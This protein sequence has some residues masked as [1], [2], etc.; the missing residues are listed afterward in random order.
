[1]GNSLS[2]INSNY[3][4]QREREREREREK[5]RYIPC[6]PTISWTSH[7]FYSHYY[8]HCLPLPLFFFSRHMYLVRFLPRKRH[9][10]FEVRRTLEADI[11]IDKYVVNAR[12]LGC[13]SIGWLVGW[14]MVVMAI[15][16]FEALEPC[17]L[18]LLTTV[19][20]NKFVL[21]FFLCCSLRQARDEGSLK[22]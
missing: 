11:A 22:I 9:I 3:S 16:L 7:L 18:F 20:E 8:H 10:V 6:P 13:W 12:R 4:P 2:T 17:F 14:F 1:M 15:V 19:T 21:L 5:E